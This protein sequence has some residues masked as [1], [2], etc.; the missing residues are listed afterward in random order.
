MSK[1]VHSKLLGNVCAGIV[2]SIAYT[3]TPRQGPGH[4]V[5]TTASPAT[6]GSQYQ[7]V[8]AVTRI[9]GLFWGEGFR[10]FMR[11][12]TVRRISLMCYLDLFL[13]QAPALRYV[14]FGPVVSFPSL[15]SFLP[16]FTCVRHWQSDTVRWISLMCFLN[17]SMYQAPA[18]R[19]V[20][21]FAPSFCFLPLFPFY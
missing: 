4:V 6:L 1:S 8:A 10:D 19:Y 13:Y 18:L 7:L 11:S 21:R 16:N 20:V 3:H 2:F 9:K 5:S 14:F 17:L 12:E 15:I